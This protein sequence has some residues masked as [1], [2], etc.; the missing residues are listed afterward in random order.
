MDEAILKRLIEKW[1][2]RESV[3]NF[4]DS[5]AGQH[6]QQIEIAIEETKKTCASEL[7]TVIEIL[8]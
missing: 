5:D 3:R 4:A 8:G 7:E 2:K 1:R 6:Q